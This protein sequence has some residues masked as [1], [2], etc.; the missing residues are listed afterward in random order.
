[1]TVADFNCMVYGDNIN[2]CSE[3]K[4]R[5]MD[6]VLTVAH[7]QVLKFISWAEFKNSSMVQNANDSDFLNLPLNQQ[8]EVLKTKN[9]LLQESMDQMQSTLMDSKNTQ[10]VLN[11]IS[12]YV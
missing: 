10:K 7:K 1:M 8:V 12:I 6:E 2:T 3:S 4:L 9:T 5:E 11:L